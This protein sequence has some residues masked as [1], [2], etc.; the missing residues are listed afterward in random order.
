MGGVENFVKEL[1]LNILL[2]KPDTEI[3]V[4]CFRRT[5]E[6]Q[7]D[8]IMNGVRVIR[9]DSLFTISSQPISFCLKNAVK[10]VLQEEQYDIINFH[11][12][13]PLLANALLKAYQETNCNAKLCVHWHGDIVGRVLLSRWYTKSTNKLLNV[14]DCVTSDTMNYA[15][16]SKLLNKYI[17]KTIVIPAIPNYSALNTDCRNFEVE[18]EI[19]SL[20][21]GRKI[22]FS[23]GRMVKWKGFQYLIESFKQLDTNKYVLLLGGYG[24]YEKRLRRLGQKMENIFFVGK[25]DE[26]TKYSY[27]TKSDLFVFPSYG[28][29]EAFGICLAEAMYCK[30]LCLAFDFDDLGAREIAIPGISCFVAKPLDADDLANQI[31][32]CCSINSC[33]KEKVVNNARA[34]IDKKLSIDYYR[35][36]IVFAYLSDE[37]I[38][39]KQNKK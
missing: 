5:K 6:E 7:K 37:L 31:V 18:K 3:T 35:K 12:P 30:T 21:K 38:S 28:R 15:V 4:L 24:K 13:N 36:Q 16:H 20:A 25:I 11:Y 22:V 2:L 1:N 27:L 32:R 14:C 8:S 34:I 9:I 39:L 33:E 17:N 10:K 19:D 29:Q 23:F 26:T